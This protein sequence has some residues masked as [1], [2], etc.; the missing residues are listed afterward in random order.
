MPKRPPHYVVGHKNPDSD[1]VVSAHV[2]AWIYRQQDPTSNA[3]PIR[4]GPANK[5]STWLFKDAGVPLPTHRKSCLYKAGEI[6][7]PVPV[8]D[9][10]CSLR[11]ALET[12]QRASADFVAVV[13]D[14]NRPL[15]IISD[16]TQRTNYLLQCN[17]EDFVGTL[18]DFTHIVAGLPLFPLRAATPPEIHRLLVPVHKSTLEGN[19]DAHT[20]VII[21][22]RE[23]FLDTINRNPPGAVIMTNVKKER[24]LELS[25]KLN[26]P[27]YL[28]E[29]TV[30]SMLTRLPGCFPASSAMVDEFAAVD[31]SANENELSRSM[32]GSDWGLLVLDS[33]GRVK[34]AISAIDLLS[35]KRPQI[36]LVDHSERGQSIHGLQDAEIIEIIDHHRLGDIE[37]IQPLSMDVRPLGSTASILHERIKES[38]LK[39]P[40]E[41]AKLLLGALVS[42]TLLLTSPTCTESDKMRAKE[43]A[44]IAGVKLRSYGIK[45]LRQNDELTTAKATKLVRKDS[46]EFT[47]EGVTFIAAQIETVDI[48]TLT[49][50]RQTEIRSAF[51]EAIRTEKVDFGA[52]MITDVLAAS[53]RLIIVSEDAKWEKVHIP[54]Q[55]QYAGSDWDEPAFVSRKKQLIPLLL[56]NIKTSLYG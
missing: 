53:S 37:T 4:L 38:R 51:A 40:P 12:M 3:T 24:A 41:I 26:C 6:A 33:N 35:L 39:I 21:G 34:G 45:V 49:P 48:S 19:W 52:V 8:V 14:D 29:G 55:V 7:T 36:S 47:F 2:L 43:L 9:V 42:D 50:E 18:L 23:L 44:T 46:K 13:D 31:V 32:K 56:K 16:R 1:T 5:Q 25:K 27:T 15:G 54:E 22:D 20:A 11:Q 10:D 28:F 17:I 30:I